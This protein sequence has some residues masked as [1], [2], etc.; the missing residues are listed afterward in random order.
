M[1]RSSAALALMVGTDPA[2][3]GGVASVVAVLQADGFFRQHA[4]KYVVSHIDGSR[5]DKLIAFWKALSILLLFCLSNSRGI[6]HAHS[7]SRASFY[8]KSLLLAVARAFGCKTI[9]HLHGGEFRQFAT[10]ESGPLMRWWI[11]R[12]LEKSSRVIALSD[13]WAAFISRFAPK[14]NV[15]VV[16]N[17]VKLN[18][19]SKHLPEEAGR[20]LFLGR[21]GKGKGVFELLTAVSLLKNTYPEIKLILGGDGDLAAVQAA[22]NDLHIEKYVEILGWVGPEQKAQELARASVF[23]LPSYDEGLPMAMLEAMAAGKAIVVTSV[24]GI[25][26]AVR[27]GENG[28]LISPRDVGALAAALKRVLDEPLLRRSLAT[29]AR[30]TIE[31]RFS[32]DVVMAKLS[33]LYG[34]L[35]GAAKK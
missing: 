21:L 35:G 5:L 9:F 34:E 15:L 14:A 17:S 26:E 10:D 7:A 2:G 22:V 20:I 3:K 16:P 24:G 23:T 27:D 19:V 28:L 30:M 13:S 4:V 8:R 1:T 31:E 6:V 33:A 32:T 11:R 18:V 12:T 29:N 25:P